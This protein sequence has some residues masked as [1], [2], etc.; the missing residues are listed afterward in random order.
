VPKGRLL[1]H[2]L[3]QIG[4]LLKG[5]DGGPWLVIPLENPGGVFTTA[6]WTVKPRVHRQSVLNYAQLFGLSID[7]DAHV[8]SM[9]QRRQAIRDDLVH[10]TGDGTDITGKTKKWHCNGMSTVSKIIDR[11]K[12]VS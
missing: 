8:T 11:Q 3:A 5:Y 4:P 2:G 6:C 12:R 7:A 9:T 10:G 1:Q